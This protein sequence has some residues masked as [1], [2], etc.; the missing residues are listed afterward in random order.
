MNIFVKGW[1][2]GAWFTRKDH[3]FF[4]DVFWGLE[5]ES[6]GFLSGKKSIN[7]MINSILGPELSEIK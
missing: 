4:T 6:T 7:F 1:I 5:D 2:G 3:R